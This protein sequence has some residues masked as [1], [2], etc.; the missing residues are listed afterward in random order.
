MKVTC[1]QCGK[2]YLVDVTKIDGDERSFMC[3]GCQNVITVRKP[4][5]VEETPDTAAFEDPVFTEPADAPVEEPL[6]EEAATGDTL[7]EDPDDPFGAA[8]DTADDVSEEP[9]IEQSFA[10]LDDAFAGD[11][12]DATADFILGGGDSEP[13]APQEEISDDLLGEGEDEEDVVPAAASVEETVDEPVAAEAAEA[14]KGSG[15][16]SLWKG[17][18]GKVVIAMLLVGVI[19]LA[20][21]GI[22]AYLLSN[23]QLNQSAEEVVQ[24]T[25]NGLSIQV[26]EWVDKNLKVLQAA[27]LMPDMV[28]MD[29]DSQE[30]ILKSISE[31]YPWVYL[32]FTLDVDGINIARSDDNQPVSYSHRRYYWDIVDGKQFAW[33]TLIEEGEPALILAAPIREEGELV[34]II[35][36]AMK[37]DD[38]AKWVA[39]QKIGETGYAAL[40]EKDGKI[41]VHPNKDLYALQYNLVGG[42]HKLVQDFKSGGENS[43]QFEWDGK[44]YFGAVKQTQHGWGLIV[45]QEQNEVYAITRELRP[46]FLGGMVVAALLAMLFGILFARG[47]VK[48]VLRLTDAADRLSLGELDVTIDVNSKDEIGQLAKS[49]TRMQDS[50]RIALEWLRSMK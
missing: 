18:T 40:V 30:I 3:R 10:D 23:T 16:F 21:F 5:E 7:T 24:E 36:A 34:G 29:P 38:I 19:P 41:I 11:D 48:P 17:L 14:T 12:G 49:I 9:A 42:G 35:A 2:K 32:S 1:D 15:S 6:M 31:A 50:L 39:N 45:Q 27:A 20:A 43:G 25:A 13:A 46:L 28:E 22:A 26:E 47:I 37:I 8:F 33:Q 4:E 44:S